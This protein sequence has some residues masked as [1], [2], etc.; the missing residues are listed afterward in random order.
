M[1]K[2]S[3]ELIVSN[4]N[5][6]TCFLF[7]YQVVGVPDARLGE[8]ICAWV[9]LKDGQTATEDDIKDFCR[10]KVRISL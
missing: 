9:Q 2:K 3:I 8:A 7:F 5:D 4:T 10:E 1:K 6:L